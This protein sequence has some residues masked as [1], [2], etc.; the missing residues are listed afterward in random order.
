MKFQINASIIQL[1]AVVFGIIGSF[2][3]AYYWWN[4]HIPEFFILNE[5][6][7]PLLRRIYY[8]QDEIA[9]LILFFVPSC[10][11][12]IGSISKKPHLLFIAFLLSIP[13][14]E[15]ISFKVSSINSVHYPLYF[16]L[17]SAILFFIASTHSKTTYK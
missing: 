5:S 9:F 8:R 1:F 2:I 12:F 15:Y 13:V 14:G 7:I 11:A 10:I 17:A 4:F 16:Y 3:G 6:D